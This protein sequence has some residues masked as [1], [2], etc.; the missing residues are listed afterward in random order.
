MKPTPDK[1]EVQEKE[2]RQLERIVNSE[3]EKRQ[4][5]EKVLLAFANEMQLRVIFGLRPF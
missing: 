4:M 1:T 5:K 3:G 2:E